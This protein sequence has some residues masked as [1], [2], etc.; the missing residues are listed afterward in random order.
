MYRDLL[1]R[2]RVH[3]RPGRNSGRAMRRGAISGGAHAGTETFHAQPDSRPS[4]AH[5]YHAQSTGLVLPGGNRYQVHS[6]H[7]PP[8]AK[9]EKNEREV[10]VTDGQQPPAG[11]CLH[12]E[13]LDIAP[14]LPVLPCPHSSRAEDSKKPCPSDQHG[15]LAILR[16]QGVVY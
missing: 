10:R 15:L 1:C 3:S 16:H 11:Y 7:T 13:P 5:Y 12:T 9:K 4:R 14:V 2:V 6:Y 8:F